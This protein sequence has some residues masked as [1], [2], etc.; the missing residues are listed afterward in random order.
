M[1][2]SNLLAAAGAIL[3][4]SAGAALAA[5]GCDCCKDM[6]PDAAMSCCDE[7]KAEPA[8]T[9]PTPPAP[10]PSDTPAPQGHAGHD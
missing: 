6:A 8:P 7:M 3:A 9:E 4:L 2:V 5:E 1:K 10:A